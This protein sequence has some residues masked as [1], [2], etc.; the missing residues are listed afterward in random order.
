MSR[1]CQFSEDFF[2]IDFQ[3]AARHAG[4]C[5]ECV[6]LLG[7]AFLQQGLSVSEVAQRLDVHT[8]AVKQWHSRFKHGG[9]EAMKDQPGK[10][11]KPLFHDETTESFKTS[12]VEL[13]E[14]KSGGRITG[15]DAQ[16]LLQ[17][18]FQITCSLST[19]YTIMHS[20]G[21]SWISGRSRHPQQRVEVQEAFKKNSPKT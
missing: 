12:I 20:A 3:H 18:K 21:L 7:L 9:L 6:R 11:R 19:T 15:Y 5:R 4:S 8:A 13:Q 14:Q 1:S 10:G 17:E 16:T 2:S